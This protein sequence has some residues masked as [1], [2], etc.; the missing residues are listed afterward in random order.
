MTLVAQLNALQQRLSDGLRLLPGATALYLN[1][2]RV[3][4][5]SDGYADLDLQVYIQSQLPCDV[6]PFFLER[7]A[8]IDVAWPLSAAVDNTGFTVLFKG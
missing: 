5:R 4:N 1:G 7:I 8:P 2:S 6:W 3:H